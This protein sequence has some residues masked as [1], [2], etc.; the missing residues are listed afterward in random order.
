MKKTKRKRKCFAELVL[1][2][3]VY[4]CHM[5]RG[6]EIEMHYQKVRPGVFVSWAAKKDVAVK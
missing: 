4:V 5:K 6:H 1:R 2:D 3:F